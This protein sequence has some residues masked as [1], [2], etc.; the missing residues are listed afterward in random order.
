MLGLYL[1]R[2]DRQASFGALDKLELDGD[3]RRYVDGLDSGN[4]DAH[5]CSV[6]RNWVPEHDVFD[7]EGKRLLARGW[8]SIL[9]ALFSKR[10]CTRERARAVFGSGIGENRYDRMGFEARQAE[11]KAKAR[12]GAKLDPRIISIGSL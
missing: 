8:R 6:P 7:A 9:A 4:R 11:A 3:A 1:R 12:L 10:L 5:V 2:R